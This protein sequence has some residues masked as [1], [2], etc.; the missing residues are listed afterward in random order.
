M[1][2][3][4]KNM[5]TKKSYFLLLILIIAIN[6][7]AQLRVNTNGSLSMGYTGY[8]NFEMGN[9]GT[10]YANGQWAWEVT[11]ENLNLWKPWPSPNNRQ[12]N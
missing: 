11:G 10:S 5:K 9:K 1:F 7:N 3:K 12:V 6:A 2:E 4:Q 8:S